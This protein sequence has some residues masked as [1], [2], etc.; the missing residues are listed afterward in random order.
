[1]NLLSKLSKEAK[2]AS[3][4][5][6]SKNLMLRVILYFNKT[7]FPTD[8]LMQ[9]LRILHNCCRTGENFM[10]I[11]FETHG[12]TQKTFDTIINDSRTMVTEAI[13]G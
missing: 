12:F 3:E 8:L 10:D 13:A 11:C 4:I 7:A 9:S 6:K 5:A 1:M 2:G